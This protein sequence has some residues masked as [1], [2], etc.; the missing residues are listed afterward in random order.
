MRLDDSADFGNE[1]RGGEY[2]EIP[3]SNDAHSTG[4]NPADSLTE[5]TGAPPYTHAQPRLTYSEAAMT[6]T[7]LLAT[8]ALLAGPAT[9]AAQGAFLS[10]G[11]G[12]G[13]VNVDHGY[14]LNQ[15]AT[16]EG[17][18]AI[19]MTAGYE[20]DSG[21]VVEG[22]ATRGLDL[23]IGNDYE[24]DEDRLMAGYAFAVGQSFQITPAAGISYWNLHVRDGILSGAP[25]A[26]FSGQ[27]WVWRI[28][29]EYQRYTRLGLYF[30]YTGAK[31]DFGA[32]SL[33]SLGLR[34]RF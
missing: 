18:W 25:T 12:F 29:G 2:V 15:T 4:V 8:L 34:Y 27:D 9:G 3:T 11:S 13:D 26:A 31:H 22:G 24:L 10:F 14:R 7:R 21:I 17:D 32:A 20:L 19:E 5:A 30:S 33:L 23:D 28:T 6:H 16:G 1:R